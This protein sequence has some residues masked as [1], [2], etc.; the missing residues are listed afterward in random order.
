M[1]MMKKAVKHRLLKRKW[2]QAH[3]GV[4][5]V[6]VKDL[7]AFAGRASHLKINNL[8]QYF[9]FV[10]RELSVN[11]LLVFIKYYKFFKVYDNDNN[12]DLNNYEILIKEIEDGLQ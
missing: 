9:E 5:Q 12:L 6:R 10:T 3:N 7:F 4:V 1:Q 2:H 11:K 8:P